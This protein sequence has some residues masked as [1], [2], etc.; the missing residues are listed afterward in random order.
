MS[1]EQHDHEQSDN[2]WQCVSFSSGKQD[3]HSDKLHQ[4]CHRISRE[5]KDIDHEIH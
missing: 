4:C 1:H 5:M 3:R 2:Q